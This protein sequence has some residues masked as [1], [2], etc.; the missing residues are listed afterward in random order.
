MS[1]HSRARGSGACSSIFWGKNGAIRCTLGVSKYDIKNLKINKSTL[2]LTNYLDVY[3]SAKVNILTFQKGGQGAIAPR[4][5][6]NFKKSNGMEA[7][8]LGRDI[9]NVFFTF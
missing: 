8:P 5:Q 7:Y 9:Q 4:S 1:I 3:V 2:T 6:I